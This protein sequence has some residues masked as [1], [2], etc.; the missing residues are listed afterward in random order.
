MGFLL[1]GRFFSTAK[2][3]QEL[4]QTKNVFLRTNRWV[5]ETKDDQFYGDWQSKQKWAQQNNGKGCRTLLAGC[6]KSYWCLARETIT[7]LP[8]NASIQ[9]SKPLTDVLRVNSKFKIYLIDN[10]LIQG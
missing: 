8:M 4:A 9:S 5:W 1:Q 2:K 7:I 3:R 10:A 6:M